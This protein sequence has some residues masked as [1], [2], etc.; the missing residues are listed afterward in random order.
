MAYTTGLRS[1]RAA[2]IRGHRTFSES[3]KH[4]QNSGEDGKSGLPYNLWPDAKLGP[5]A[6]QDARFP[7]PGNVGLAVQLQPNQPEVWR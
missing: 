1:F 4:K 2:I 3:T 7:L 5:L 6:P